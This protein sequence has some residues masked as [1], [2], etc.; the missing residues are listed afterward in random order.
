MRSAAP[1]NQAS[2]SIMALKQKDNIGLLARRLHAT[3]RGIYRTGKISKMDYR[4]DFSEAIHQTTL[5]IS[6]FAI[7]YNMSDTEERLAKVD[8]TIGHFEA[9]RAIIEMMFDE[10]VIT[11]ERRSG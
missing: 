8:E 9:A 11:G 2:I 6:S 4:L 7:A 1:H 10:K 5:T 3:L